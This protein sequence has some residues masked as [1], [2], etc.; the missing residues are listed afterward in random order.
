MTTTE[1]MTGLELNSADRNLTCLAVV[2]PDPISIIAAFTPHDVIGKIRLSYFIIR[3]N[4]N[5][6]ETDRESFR[7]SFY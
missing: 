1:Q 5:L 7:V 4:Y 2:G 3:V 6:S